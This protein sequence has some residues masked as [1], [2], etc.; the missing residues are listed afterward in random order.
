MMY[1]KHFEGFIQDLKNKF[2]NVN[3]GIYN[4][5]RYPDDIEDQIN[6]ISQDLVDDFPEL[7]FKIYKIGQPGGTGWRLESIDLPTGHISQIHR[8]IHGHERRVFTKEIIDE[9]YNNIEKNYFPAIKSR[10]NDINIQARINRYEKIGIFKIYIYLIPT[11]GF[12]FFS[13]Y[14]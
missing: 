3:L 8:D 13:S 10:L 5:K 7:D 9:Y 6:E 14:R 4:S 12:H 1:I 11:K 2:T